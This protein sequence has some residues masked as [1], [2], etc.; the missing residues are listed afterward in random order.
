MRA[1]PFLLSHSVSGRGAICQAVALI[2]GIGVLAAGPE[3][4][5]GE[6]NLLL[7][8]D[9]V[10]WKPLEWMPW[11][12]G[13]RLLPSMQHRLEKG[14]DVLDIRSTRSSDYGSWR[15][16]VHGI[17]GGA[18]YRF[19]AGYKSA[20]V[21]HEDLSVFGV[22]SWCLDSDCRRLIRREYAGQA[23]DSETR[24]LVLRSRAPEGAL[25][26]RL[27]LGLRWAGQ[28]SVEF[29]PLEL[30]EL[31]EGSFRRVR[32]ATTKVRPPVPSTLEGNRAILSQMLD[33]AG[34]EKPDLIVLSETLFDYGV[35]G[36]VDRRCARAGG[37]EFQLL[38]SK[39]RELHTWIVASLNFCE[40]DL[41]YNTAW[42]LN[43]EGRLAG[44]YR[45]VHLPLSEAEA[46]V[47]PGTNHAVFDTD[48]G[49]IGL[50][51]CWDVWF[52]EAARI[53]GLA[54]AEMILA[55]VAGDVQPRHWDV[56]SRARALDN[57]LYFISANT[58]EGSS[59]RIVSPE[60]E[61]LAETDAA[62]GVAVAEI[63]LGRE[64]GVRWLSVGSSEGI[65]S[66]LY[67]RERRPD[68]YRPLVNAASVP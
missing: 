18:D 61:V 56:V 2:I 13:D 48:F 10:T 28:G 15:A 4:L 29:G 59:S 65:P 25:S 14:R 53:L 36:P 45:K 38:S 11:A 1:S 50:L 47:T 52:P 44:E 19:V 57:A 64:Q 20:G 26:V 34:S 54:G 6:R 16:V 58:E 39:A 3:L 63:E 35:P 43:R 60:G 5:Q 66:Q 41:V 37:P 27:E 32:I 33:R 51:I 46:G 49:R 9:G 22:L 8:S 24:S 68:T 40:G 62:F 21:E 7:P 31:P 23:A 30:S 67:R 55:P 17:R 12:P 42:L